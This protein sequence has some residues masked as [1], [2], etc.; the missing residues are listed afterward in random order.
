M[1]FGAKPNIYRITLLGITGTFTGNHTLHWPLTIPS[2][3]KYCETNY[4]TVS[5]FFL[6]T[7]IIHKC[8]YIENLRLGLI[9]SR[10]RG[11]STLAV[12]TR[13]L[14][15]LSTHF[16]KEYLTYTLFNIIRTLDHCGHVDTNGR[17]GPA[18]MERRT[19]I[20]PI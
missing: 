15:D 5:I 7:N 8:R 20:T 10:T 9:H 12:C 17:H 1:W 13:Q 6:A 11:G 18:Y 2:G 19:P 3:Q 4:L 14:T 16:H